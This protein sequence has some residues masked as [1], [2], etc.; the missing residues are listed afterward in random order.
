MTITDLTWLVACAIS[1]STWIYTWRWIHWVLVNREQSQSHRPRGMELLGWRGE[2]PYY[3]DVGAG[4]SK[5]TWHASTGI[6]FQAGKA[7]DLWLLYRHLELDLDSTRLIDKIDMS[8]PT[9]GVIYRW[10]VLSLII[11]GSYV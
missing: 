11:L 2:P 4:E 3:I 9:M 8:G 7:W 5:L 1:I 6:G 10:W